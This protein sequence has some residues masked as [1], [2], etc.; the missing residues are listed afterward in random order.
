MLGPRKLGKTK[1]ERIN[2]NFFEFNSKGLNQDRFFEV[3][4]NVE[5]LGGAPENDERTCG[6]VRGQ[7]LK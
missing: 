5:K 7:E 6:K 3:P 4:K 1:I 2:S